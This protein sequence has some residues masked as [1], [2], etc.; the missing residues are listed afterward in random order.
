MAKYKFIPISTYKREIGVF[1]GSRSDFIEWIE[2]FYKDDERYDDLVNLARNTPRRPE[3]ASF[4]HNGATGDGI[5]E[6]HKFPR[7]P[8]E[9]A[10]AAHEALHA[11][12]QILDFVNVEYIKNGSNES[13]TYLLEQIVKELLTIEDYKTY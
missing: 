5:I 9:T 1:I 13:F 12:F 6:L 8:I 2:E 7:T 4:W 10:Q 11:V 3:A